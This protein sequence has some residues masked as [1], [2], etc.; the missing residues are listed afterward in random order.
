[1]DHALQ[2]SESPL[3]ETLEVVHHEDER[4]Y[5]LMVDGQFGG[6]LVYGRGD[7]RIVFTHTFIAEG[8]R[9]RGLSNFMI[10]STLDDVRAHGVT[11]TNFCPVLDH[12]FETHPGYIPLIDEHV[13]GTW[14]R[15][16]HE[17]RQ[18]SGAASRG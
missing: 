15:R 12:F 16:D 7:H 5:E 3:G 4:F 2:Q 18:P 1:M 14:S 9:G 8:F 6:L 11:V 13:P 17:G 10:Q